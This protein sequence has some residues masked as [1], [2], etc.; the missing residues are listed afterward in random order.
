MSK[1]RISDYDKSLIQIILVVVTGFVSLTYL[2]GAF[3]TY[4]P[5]EFGDHSGAIGIVAIFAAGVAFALPFWAL[6]LHLLMRAFKTG[7]RWFFVT[8]W[9]LCLLP[10]I[11]TAVAMII[12]W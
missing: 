9:I 5:D 11:V 1:L 12:W 10:P 8:I 4:R 2:S 3:G 6:S 7:H